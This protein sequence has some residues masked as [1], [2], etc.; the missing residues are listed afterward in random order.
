MVML[1]RQIKAF[2]EIV[3]A[4]IKLISILEPDE[5]RPCSID[6]KPCKTLGIMPHSVDDND[7]IAF[8]RRSRW[9]PGANT[10]TFLNPQKFSRLRIVRYGFFETLE[11]ELDGFQ[12]NSRSF[13]DP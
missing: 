3:N 9:F 13:Y 12:L 11:S 5:T 4:A 8:I 2:P 7:A 1:G 10:A 6:P